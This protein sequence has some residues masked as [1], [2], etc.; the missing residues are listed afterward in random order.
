MPPVPRWPS[1][2]YLPRKALCSPLEQLVALPAGKKT[3]GDQ[4]GGNEV[5]V[6]RLGGSR[7]RTYVGERSAQLIGLDQLA[8]FDRFDELFDQIIWP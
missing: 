1:S 6:F 7:S 8:T 5:G 3:R 4:C 2:L